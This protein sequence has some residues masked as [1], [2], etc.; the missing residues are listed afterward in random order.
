[1]GTELYARG[2]IINR[3]FDEL[4]L[5]APSIIREIHQNYIKSAGEIIETNTFG[6]NAKRLSA[7]GLGEKMRVINEAAVRLAREAAGTDAFVAG[8]VGPLGCPLE[9]LGSTSFAEAR[10]IFRQQIDFF[11]EA[12]VD[13][14]MLETF[15]EITNSGK[16]TS[17]CAKRPAA[18]SR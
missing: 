12:G 7:L 2:I 1:M 15:T 11:L 13:L 16:P 17:L 8:A 5:S 14:H 9:P 4:N 10:P 6:A 3:C 18:A